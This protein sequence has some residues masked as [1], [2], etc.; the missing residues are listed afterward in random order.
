[1][2]LRMPCNL[3]MKVRRSTTHHD[4]EKTGLP[5]SDQTSLP[6]CRQ[7][8]CG[9]TELNLPRCRLPSESQNLESQKNLCVYRKSRIWFSAGKSGSPRSLKLEHLGAQQVPPQIPPC[10]PYFLGFVAAGPKSICLECRSLPLC[11]PALY[12]NPAHFEAAGVR[13]S[14]YLSLCHCAFDIL[15]LT[16]LLVKSVSECGDRLEILESPVI[17]LV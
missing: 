12:L 17:M 5:M 7:S 13:R 2:E 16:S 11:C 4:R 6:N 9:L 1:M 10:S 8:E 3:P 15:T 14:P